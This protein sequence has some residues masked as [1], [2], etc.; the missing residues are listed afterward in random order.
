MSHN[1]L[2][3]LGFTFESIYWLHNGSKGESV[4]LTSI[5]ISVKPKAKS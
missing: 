5:P 4:H 2:S 1:K 3:Y